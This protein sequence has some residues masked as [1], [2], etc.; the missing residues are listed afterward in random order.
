MTTLNEDQFKLSQIGFGTVGV[1]TEVS[2][3]YYQTKQYID[4]TSTGSGTHTFNYPPINVSITGRIGVAITN[5]QNFNA[6][7]QP[8]F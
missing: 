5:P 6:V 3:F 7:L 4:L 1:A 2:N 8:I